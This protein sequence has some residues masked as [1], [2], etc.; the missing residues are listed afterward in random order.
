M[1]SL[2]LRTVPVVTNAAVPGL[3]GGLKLLYLVLSLVLLYSIS[4]GCMY[5]IRV[6]MSCLACFIIVIYFFS[7]RGRVPPYASYLFRCDIVS[8]LNSLCLVVPGILGTEA[9]SPHSLMLS[10]VGSLVVSIIN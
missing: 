1:R 2:F 9:A 4:M 7:C 5:L 8:V 10:L 6:S 3:F